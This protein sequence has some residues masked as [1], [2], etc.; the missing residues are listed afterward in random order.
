MHACTLVA[1]HH[2]EVGLVEVGRLAR[3]QSHHTVG[4][5]VWDSYPCVLG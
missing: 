3:R 1:F 4:C 5:S 2:R